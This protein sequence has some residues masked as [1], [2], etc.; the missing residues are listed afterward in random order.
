MKCCWKL[1]GEHLRNLR[2]LSLAFL[3]KFFA[4]AWFCM[5]P[6]SMVL[7]Y[8]FILQKNL[9]DVRTILNLPP[10]IEHGTAHWHRLRHWGNWSFFSI[11]INFH[12]QKAEPCGRTTQSS[13]GL[14]CQAQKGRRTVVDGWG[15]GGRGI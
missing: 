9:G 11:W 8:F 7:N 13:A 6:R 14:H 5:K 4:P 10:N 15:G 1:F 12:S 2:S 3:H